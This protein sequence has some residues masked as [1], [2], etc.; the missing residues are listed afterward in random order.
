MAG[1][2][3]LAAIGIYVI[4]QAIDYGLGTLRSIGP[5]LFPLISGVLLTLLGLLLLG[6]T[7]RGRSVSEGEAPT[8]RWGAAACVFGGLIAWAVLTPRFGLVPGTT[9]MILLTS[10]AA[11]RPKVTLILGLIVTLCL[12]GY[13]LFSKGLGL[14]LPAFN[15]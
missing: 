4:L 10:F 1:G 7:L 14:P 9:V 13:L 5:G 8:I 3:I 2:S 15:F 12:F 6:I 11:G